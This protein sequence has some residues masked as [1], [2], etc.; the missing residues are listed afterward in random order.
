MQIEKCV[1]VTEQFV[2]YSTTNGTIIAVPL[3]KDISTPTESLHMA[4]E[5]AREASK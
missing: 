4:I 3:T 5:L 2:H 1:G